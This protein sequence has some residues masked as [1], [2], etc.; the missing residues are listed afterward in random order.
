M[1][2]RTLPPGVSAVEGRPAPNRITGV[3]SKIRTPRSSS[4]RR[5]PRARRAG[6]TVTPSRSIRPPR[7]VGESATALASSAVR[8]RICSEAPNRAAASTFVCHAPSFA[9]LVTTPMSPARVNHA[10]TAFAE[11]NASMPFTARVPA[12]Q[13]ARVAS[14]P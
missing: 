10:S 13:S 12:P 4:T 9:A 7:N 2:A 6:C 8:T 1:P 3:C 11:Q 14:S 5:M